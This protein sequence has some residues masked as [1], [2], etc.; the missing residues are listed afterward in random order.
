MFGSGLASCLHQG[1]GNGSVVLLWTC[2]QESLS[3]MGASYCPTVCLL[4]SQFVW[5]CR[6]NFRDVILAVESNLED[7]LLPIAN[8]M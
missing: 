7:E 5:C 1:K 2:P 6:F 3:F 4:L 8:P